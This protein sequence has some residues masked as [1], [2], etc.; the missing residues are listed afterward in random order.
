MARSDEYQNYIEEIL[1]EYQRCSPAFNSSPDEWPDELIF[2]QV[3][4]I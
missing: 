4:I 3:F 2:V 1:S